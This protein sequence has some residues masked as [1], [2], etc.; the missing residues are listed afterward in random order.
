MVHVHSPVLIES[1][2]SR[3]K[4]RSLNFLKRG[5]IW[6]SLTSDPTRGTGLLP[7][8][9]HLRGEGRGETGLT[10][11]DQVYTVLEDFVIAMSC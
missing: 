8:I 1:F 5:L 9:I 10:P 11:H 2:H 3:Q 7:R 6:K 4:S